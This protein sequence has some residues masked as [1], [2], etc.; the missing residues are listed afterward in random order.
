MM[1]KSLETRQARLLELLATITNEITAA[2]ME[3]QIAADE[4]RRLR[5]EAENA[6]LKVYTEAEAAAELKIGETTL[7]HMRTASTAFPCW[8]AGS[9]VRYTNFHLIEI[10]EMLDARARQREEAKSKRKGRAHLRG[11]AARAS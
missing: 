8:R 6:N 3:L 10:V 5:H 9:S 11:V 2:R 7:R 4:N 1:E